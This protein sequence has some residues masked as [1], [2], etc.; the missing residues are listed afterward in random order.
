LNRLFT[1]AYLPA[2]ADD[3]FL[4]TVDAARRSTLVAVADE[5]GFGFGFHLQGERETVFLTYPRH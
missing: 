3:A 4:Q 1:R 5:T 2:A